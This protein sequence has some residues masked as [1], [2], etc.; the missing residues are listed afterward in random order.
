MLNREL[1]MRR[2]REYQEVYLHGTKVFGRF[3][4]VFLVRSD[5]PHNR[6]GIVASKKLGKAAQRNLWKRR[7]REIVRSL[8]ARLEQ[9]YDVV[10]LARASARNADYAQLE[11]D[12]ARALGR[13]RLLRGKVLP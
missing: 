7:M 1:R 3:V 4:V 8:D 12:L 10:L 9:G 5:R 6:Y 11:K 13:A 2:T